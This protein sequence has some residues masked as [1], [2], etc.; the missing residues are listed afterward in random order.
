VICFG[1]GLCTAQASQALVGS[2]WQE[3]IDSADQEEGRINFWMTRPVTRGSKLKLV[4]QNGIE[5]FWTR[6]IRS[7]PV[8]YARGAEMSSRER[9]SSAEPCCLKADTR[10]NTAAQNRKPRSR[11]DHDFLFIQPLVAF[12]FAKEPSH[13]RTPELSGPFAHTGFEIGSAY[14]QKE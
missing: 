14:D 6:L 1:Q 2:V 4:E 3:R 9:C 10:A 13:T 11:P 5:S 12:P 8:A 7:A